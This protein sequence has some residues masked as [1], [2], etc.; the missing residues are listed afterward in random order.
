MKEA[1]E[2]SLWELI[3]ILGVALLLMVVLRGCQESSCAD[4]GGRL[5]DSNPRSTLCVG[6]DGRIIP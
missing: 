5:A 1:G 3:A 6:P 4:K 2:A